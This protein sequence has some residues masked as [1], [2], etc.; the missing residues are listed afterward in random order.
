MTDFDS[1]ES[2]QGLH[3]DLIALDQVRLRNIDKLWA[4]LDARVVEFRKLLDKSPKNEKSRRT[5]QTGM[6]TSL[7]SFAVF[8]RHPRLTCALE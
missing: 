3:Q 6:Y 4:D 8:V 2:L 7:F 5:L 1:L